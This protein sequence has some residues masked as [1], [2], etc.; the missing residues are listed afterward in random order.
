MSLEMEELKKI[1]QGKGCSDCHVDG[2]TGKAK[3]IC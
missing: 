2:P 3:S 1:Y